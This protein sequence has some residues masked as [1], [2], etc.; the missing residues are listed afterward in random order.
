MRA[1]RDDRAEAGMI[2]E[3]L[4]IGL[5][6]IAAVGLT[7]LFSDTERQDMPATLGMTPSARTTE[8]RTLL[9]TTAPPTL[10]WSDLSLL[11][12]GQT[13]TYDPT[14][15]ADD[16][17]CIVLGNACAAQD[18]ARAI[19][20]GQELRV[21]HAAVGGRK[22]DIRHTDANAIIYTTQLAP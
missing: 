7:W 2:G 22:L 19:A 18:P 21:H 3:V 4:I 10:P 12:Q 17:Y 11:L 20:A 5:I 16:T 9:I 14:L 15:A 13:L 1:R 6:V 8:T